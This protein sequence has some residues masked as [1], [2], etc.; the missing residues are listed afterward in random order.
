[1]KL[2]LP[3]LRKRKRQVTPPA[4]HGVHDL[5]RQ[6]YQALIDIRDNP[7]HA[8]RKAKE[9]LSGPRP[10]RYLYRALLEIQ[11]NPEKAR[12]LPAA[13]VLEAEIAM[14]LHSALIEIRNKPKEAIER[15]MIAIAE[16]ARM[17]RQSQ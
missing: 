16:G 6:L 13:A 7:K 8:R 2:K 12:E 10:W 11:A 1:M 4:N 3:W 5:S 15:S 17:G 14:K 9:A